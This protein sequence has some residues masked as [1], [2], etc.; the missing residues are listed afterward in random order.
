MPTTFTMNW[1]HDSPTH[2]THFPPAIVTRYRIA[3]ISIRGDLRPNNEH[4]LI[5]N[6]V[7]E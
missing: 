4:H 7:Y 6:Y 1:R 2:L 5:R 3:Y